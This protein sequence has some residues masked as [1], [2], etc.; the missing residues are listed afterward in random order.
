MQKA[1]LGLIGLVHEEA[2]QDY[3]GTMEKVAALGYQGIEGGESL[4]QGDVEANVK[5]F[6]DIGLQVLT[7]SSGKDQLSDN[8]D[9]LIAKAKSLHTDRVTVWWAPCD[10]RQAVLEDA[11]LYN[12]VGAKMAQEGIT[13]CYHNHHHEFLNVFDGVYAL[14]LL[15]ANTDP[16]ALKFVVD[17]AWVTFGGEDP[18]R[19]LKRLKG[20]IASVHVKDFARLDEPGH[21]TAVGTG[22]VN[23]KGSVQTATEIGVEWMVV[24]Q[25]TLRNLNAMET[26]TLSA[27]Y[28]REAGLV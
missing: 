5:R 4:L 26:V 12:E 19:V 21:F 11:A 3:W 15:A 13:L 9:N 23:V 6:H 7:I 16:A 10:S 27:L 18:V 17:V 8:V 20:R 1:K 22:V 28:L 24:E 25:D 14:D 2:K